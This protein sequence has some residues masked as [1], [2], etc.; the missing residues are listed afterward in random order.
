MSKNIKVLLV[1][2]IGFPWGGVSQRYSDLLDSSLSERVDLIFFE[3][4]P[5]KRSIS[6]TGHLNSQNIIGFFAVTVQYIMQLFKQN[7]SIVHIASAF[8]YSFTK[9]SILIIIAK[10]M[11]LKVILA[12]HCSISV[13]I[14]KSKISF[15]WMKYVLNKCDGC[16]FCQANGCPFTK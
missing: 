12:P 13:F 2:H 9:N 1:A 8:G 10:L 11:G 6:S 7:P 14:P 15:R 5:N 4:S 3:S 16:W